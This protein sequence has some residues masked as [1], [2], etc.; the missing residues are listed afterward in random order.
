MTHHVSEKN[1]YKMSNAE[2]SWRSSDQKNP[3]SSRAQFLYTSS[4]LH[5]KGNVNIFPG[6]L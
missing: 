6:Q 5:K 1:W 4:M 2:T 3:S